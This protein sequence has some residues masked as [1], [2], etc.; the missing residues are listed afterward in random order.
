MNS[1]SLATSFLLLLCISV[2]S[3]EQRSYAGS[4]TRDWTQYPAIVS[5]PAPKH[6][7]ALGDV[8][9]DYDRLVQLLAAGKIIDGVPASPAA[10]HWSAGHAVLVCTGDLIDKYDHGIE[11]IAVMRSLQQQAAAEGGEVIVTLGNHEAEFLAARGDDKK[12]AEFAGELKRAGVSPADVALG[13]DPGGIGAWLRNLPA[14]AKVGDWFFCHAGDTG[15]RTLADLESEI[16]QQVTA[17]GWSAPILAD[18]SSMLEARMHPRPWWDSEEPKLKDIA[19]PEKA[20]KG[21]KEVH[22]TGDASEEHRLTS[23]VEALARVTWSL[24]ISLAELDFSTARSGP[25]GRCTA[26][27]TVWCS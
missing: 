7:Y 20:K 8:H 19:K 26:S 21:K 14:G 4:V 15:G 24:A 25:R 2:V 6:L 11:V 18:S 9:G 10:V 5:I 17:Q 22:E 23:F 13:R 1:R 16:Q 3:A 12:S 27:T